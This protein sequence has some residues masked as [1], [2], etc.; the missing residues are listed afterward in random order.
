MKRAFATTLLL[1]LLIAGLLV[2]CTTKRA[3]DG[4]NVAMINNEAITNG[5]LDTRLKVYELFFRQ[6]VNDP[7]SKQQLLDQMVRER[8]ILQQA[9]PLG[10]TVTDDQVETEMAKFLDALEQQYQGREAV[11]S[12]LA[13]LGLTNENI[14]DFLRAFLLS[15]A[16]VEKKDAEVTVTA[17]EVRAFYDQNVAQLYTFKEDAVRAAHVLLPLDQ[18]EKARDVSARAR[19]GEE[20]AALAKSY[21]IDTG[22]AQRGGDL[23]YFT[24]GEMVSEFADAAFAMGVGQISDPVKSQFGWHVIK[25]LDKAGPGQ[26]PFEKARDDAEAKGLSQ[27]QDQALQ[28]WTTDLEKAAKIEKATLK[29]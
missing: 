11:T 17:D 22:S 28:K 2:S 10:A 15:Q 4:D 1:L 8:L 3:L 16:I 19:A 6:P 9:G 13:E 29:T 12:R 18:E 27:K 26:L 25:L 24:H 21:S 14:A 5:D 7:A 23:G 20:F